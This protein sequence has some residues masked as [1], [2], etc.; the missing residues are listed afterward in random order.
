MKQMMIL[1]K[2][3]APMERE[4]KTTNGDVKKVPFRMVLLSDGIDSIYGETSERLTN[5]I[6]STNDALKLNPIVGHVYNVDFTLQA[7]TYKDKE[8]REG[9]FFSCTINKMESIL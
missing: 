3:S 5:R 1:M 8:G 4:F 2:V 7:R 9:I 6:D